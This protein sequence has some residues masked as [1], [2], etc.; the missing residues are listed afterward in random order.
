MLR[1]DIGQV[2]LIEALH[3]FHLSGPLKLNYESFFTT[4][5][6]FHDLTKPHYTRTLLRPIII[7]LGLR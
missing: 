2:I 4:T 7:L 6:H 5:F 3:F 1:H